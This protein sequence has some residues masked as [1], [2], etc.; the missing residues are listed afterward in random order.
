MPAGMELF[1]ALDQEQLDFI[2]TVIDD[3]DYYIIILG[4]RYGSMNAEGIGYTEAE[5]DYAVSKDIKVI[6]LVHADPGA[7]PA[8]KSELKEET[9]VKLEAF[10][11][12]LLTGRLARHWEKAEELPGLVAL[13]LSKTIRTYPAIGWVRGDQAAS[14]ASL[15]RISELTIENAS[16]KEQ[17]RELRA[18]A[19]PPVPANLSRGADKFTVTGTHSEHHSRVSRTYKF[20]HTLSWDDLFNMV[21]FKIQK[22]GTQEYVKIILEGRLAKQYGHSSCSINDHDFET[23]QA[24][25]VALRLIK[26]TVAQSLKGT[27][28][29]WWE[30]TAYGLQYLH[31]GRLVRSA[32][33][34]T[35]PGQDSALP[36]LDGAQAE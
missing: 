32:T 16:L 27:T 22:P 35:D 28:H 24:Q 5:Y 10:R 33:D 9:R 7:L 14:A 20:A 12:K 6:A 36:P 19:Q 15:Q 30:V 34:G 18:L 1:P 29:I 11:T 3:S 25:F 8:V 31:E 23:I 26:T 17:L 2:K 21:G 4:G 13:S